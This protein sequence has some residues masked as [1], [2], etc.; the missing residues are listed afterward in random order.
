[1]K[2][3]TL[4]CGEDDVRLPFYLPMEIEILI[5]HGK[6]EDLNYLWNKDLQKT[7]IFQFEK[8]YTFAWEKGCT[9]AFGVLKRCIYDILLPVERGVCL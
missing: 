9:L 8:K 6:I 5:V 3:G 1:M 4:G 7:D 2:K